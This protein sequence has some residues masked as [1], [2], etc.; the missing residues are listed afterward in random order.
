MTDDLDV[1]VQV[2]CD[3][4]Q[5]TGLYRGY[6]EEH[7]GPGVTRVCVRCKGTG[8]AKIQ[9]TRFTGRKL[10]TGT[11]TRILRTR[12]DVEGITFEQFQK[13]YPAAV[14]E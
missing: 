7:K 12:E 6:V 9:Y 14:P 1:E 4:C 5:G 11:V 8:A 3:A 10:E 13:E 2:Q